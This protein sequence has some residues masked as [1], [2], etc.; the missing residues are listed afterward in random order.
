M[1]KYSICTRSITCPF[2]HLSLAPLMQSSWSRLTP[3]SSPRR[4]LRMCCHMFTAGCFCSVLI[5]R[6]VLRRPWCCCCCCLLPAKKWK[7]WTDTCCRDFFSSLCHRCSTPPVVGLL[8]VVFL[9]PCV[10][11]WVMALVL[12]GVNF[13]RSCLWRR[14]CLS[15]LRQADGLDVGTFIMVGSSNAGVGFFELGRKAGADDL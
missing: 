10:F 7:M 2:F 4:R 1:L 6:R 13:P 14:W 12:L 8:V 15:L 9:C 5:I 3:T 11:K